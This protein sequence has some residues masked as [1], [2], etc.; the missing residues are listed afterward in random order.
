ME[1]RRARNEALFR[2]VNERIEDISREFAA[3]DQPAERISFVCE[4]GI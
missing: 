4:C 3:S 1:N 2:E